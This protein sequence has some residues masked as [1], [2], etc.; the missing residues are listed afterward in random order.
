MTID[1]TYG[2]FY[3]GTIMKL[4]HRS[5]LWYST[6]F[7]AVHRF[8]RIGSIRLLFPVIRVIFIAP[9]VTDHMKLYLRFNDGCY[10]IKWRMR[11]STIVKLLSILP[12]S[13]FD[14]NLKIDNNARP[15]YIR[16]LTMR[17]L[18]KVIFS[19]SCKRIEILRKY[20]EK[21]RMLQISI[22]IFQPADLT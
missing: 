7:P 8:T 10:D 3:P 1:L 9:K 19:R 4:L 6:W 16:N 11:A 21:W 12:W 2:W 17:K 5:F 22:K 20:H 15:S 13:L 18:L 14:E